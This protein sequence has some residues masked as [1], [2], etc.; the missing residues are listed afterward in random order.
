[1]ALQAKPEGFLVCKAAQRRSADKFGSLEAGLRVAALVEI[2]VLRA[3][4][5]PNWQAFH[6]GCRDSLERVDATDM[7]NIEGSLCQC[8]QLDGALGGFSLKQRPARH[9]VIERGGMA[10]SDTF[11]HHTMNSDADLGVYHDH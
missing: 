11:T 4:L 5:A 10:S 8:S 3:G 9:S 1:M 7:H 2:K 6:T